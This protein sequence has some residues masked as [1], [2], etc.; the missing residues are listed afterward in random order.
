[1]IL[2]LKI[3]LIFGAYAQNEWI[4]TFEI[5]SSSTLN[6]LHYAIN[7]AIDF[8]NDHLYE[9]YAS[10]TDRSR[11]RTVFDD[12]NDGLFKEIGRIYPL[13]KGN[14]LFYLFDYGDHWLFK[15]SK[16]RKKPHE[17]NPKI[18]YPRLIESVGEPPV[19]YPS[20]E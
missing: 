7:A 20:W 5:E 9:F 14:K 1:M 15:I 4:G 2:T 19:Q 16:S 3:E 6:D 13:E 18:K 11:N 12:E 10:K 17:A 8:D